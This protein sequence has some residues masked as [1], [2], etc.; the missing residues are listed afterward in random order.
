LC[1]DLVAYERQIGRVN[2]RAAAGAAATVRAVTLEQNV[3]NASPLAS[4]RRLSASNTA[5][6]SDSLCACI[7]PALPHAIDDY[8]DLPVAERAARRLGEG[9]IAV[10]GTPL[11]V[12]R[13]SVAAS[14]IRR[15][16]ESA[17]P[18]AAPPL[19][20][21]PWHPAQFVAYRM[22]NSVGT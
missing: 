9:C 4:D 16:M 5:E 1:G 15:N 20:S 21:A 2:D 13:R 19:R 17:R 7:R 14:A 10:P 8:V 18:R 6:D 12:M 11:A 3:A 22:S